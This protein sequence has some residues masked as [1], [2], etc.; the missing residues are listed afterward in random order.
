MKN[1]KITGILLTF[2][3]AFTVSCYDTTGSSADTVS[4]EL[5]DIQTSDESSSK[6]TGYTSDTAGSDDAAGTEEE[7]TGS[8]EENNTDEETLG[9]TGSNISIASIKELTYSTI[10]SAI[11]NFTENSDGIGSLVQNITDILHAYINKSVDA[12]SSAAEK[13][14]EIQALI[15]DI[16]DDGVFT[17]TSDL[18]YALAGYYSFVYT[19]YNVLFWEV[20]VP[21]AI[22]YNL[23]M[24]WNGFEYNNLTLQDGY[25]KIVLTKNFADAITEIYTGE[26]DIQNMTIQD[27]VES[28]FSVSYLADFEIDYLDYALVATTSVV[29][30]FENG[31]PL[32]T[33]GMINFGNLAYEI[34]L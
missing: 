9:D 14:A 29:Q 13:Y 16:T 22:C 7:T 19:T 26:I 8:D 23:E 3:V 24:S 15:E 4:S 34:N 17:Y 32:S 25:I 10:E 20:E 6:D 21:T 12:D 5:T 18:G 28:S 27:I 2:L 1:K 11:N 30:E 31:S 33:T